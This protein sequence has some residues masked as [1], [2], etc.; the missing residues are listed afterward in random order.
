MSESRRV[1]LISSIPAVTEKNESEKPAATVRLVV[2]LEESTDVTC[3]EFS[4]VELVKNATVSDENG[5]ICC[6]G[7]REY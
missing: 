4:Y 7:G 6:N 5:D 2:T 3:P 1:Q